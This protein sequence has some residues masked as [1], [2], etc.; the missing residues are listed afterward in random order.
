MPKS[1]SR[2][3]S[4]RVMHKVRGTHNI[5]SSSTTSVLRMEP[6]P[7][8]IWDNLIDS[9][10]VVWVVDASSHVH[11]SLYFVCCVLGLDGELL[12]LFSAKRRSIDAAPGNNILCVFPNAAVHA[13]HSDPIQQ[14][15]DTI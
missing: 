6:Y 5:K 11:R 13:T 1:L 3:A 14:I 15:L 10:Q 12:L 9:L 8:C 4:S 7:P 2:I